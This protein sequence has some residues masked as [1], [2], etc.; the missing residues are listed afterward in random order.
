MTKIVLLMIFIFCFSFSLFAQNQNA[1]SDTTDSQVDEVIDWA[2]QGKFNPYIEVTAGLAQLQHEKFQGTLPEEGLVEV[3][4]GYGQIQQY[5]KIV[6]ELDQRFVFGSYMDEDVASFTSPQVGDF[7]AKITRFGFGNRVGYGYKLGPIE[8]LPYFQSGLL[9]TK[10]K[11]DTLNDLSQHD[12]DILAR[13]EN[14]FRFGMQTE[15]GIQFQLLE[16]IGLVTSYELSVIYPRHLFM[17]WLGSYIIIQAGEGM[18]SVFADDIIK[19]SPFFGPIF[20]F[21]LKNGLAY[22]FYQGLKEDM[23]WPFNSET[24]MTM[25]NIKFGI[26]ITF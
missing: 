10:I 5:E 23:N 26:S 20:Y 11:T 13:Y 15:G 9:W 21:L 17:E 22:A 14:V 16:S 7:K 18:V 12:K 19:S 25:E 4:L 2:W 1:D 24:P 8:L 6:W 3:K